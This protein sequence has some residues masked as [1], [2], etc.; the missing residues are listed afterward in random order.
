MR[1]RAVVLAL[2]IV[3]APPGGRAA[4]LV[5]WWDKGQY[6]QE[7]EAL[8]EIIAAFEQKT[9]K[10]VEL[11]FHSQEELPDK[12][13]GTF[14]TGRPPDF[15]FG[16]DIPSHIGRWAFDDRLVDL[17]DAIG[18]FSDLFDPE[19]LSAAMWLNGRSGHKAL[20]GLPM[21]RT[22]SHLHIWKSL[23]ER[24]GF[25]LADIPKEW[26]AFWDF[27]CDE[28]QPAVRRAT[29]REDVWGVGLPMAVEI[30]TQDGF[31]QFLAAY[32]AEY[33]T[34]AGRL[35]ID[36][37]VIRQKLI[38]VVERYT[39]FYRKGCTPP[40][41]VSWDPSGNNK[42]FLAQTVVMTVN[43]T[44]SI[45][46]AL[47]RERPDDYYE[48]TATVEWPL[49]PSGEPFPIL[50]FVSLAV[51]FKDADHV[52]T[53]K[54]FVRFLVGEGWLMHYLDFSGERMLPPLA[55]L[56]DQPFWL[57]PRDP[58]RMAA[59]MQVSSRPLAHN[60]TQALGDWR[61]DEIWE[62]FTWAKAIHR[63]VTEG[64]SP[65]QAVDEAIARIK[66]ILSG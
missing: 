27:W 25:T 24:A 40:D 57:D 46:N 58:H 53:A 1:A 64:I 6:A 17:T 49:G 13:V 28:V 11:A 43:Q 4:D 31:F 14:A 33:V 3:L 47:K 32:K 41:S 35:V 26:D 23:L 51:V 56:L 44:L 55:K 50:G 39:A 66:Q 34:R 42:A 48:H 2:A 45:P 12:I 60:Y 61:H 16:F 65:E 10:Q 36:D 54:E 63:V 30:D 7:D 21:G 59:V 20:Y 9:R 18:H 38:K 29:G 15:A 8:R 22:I 37:P 5:V 19:V 62:E 52:G